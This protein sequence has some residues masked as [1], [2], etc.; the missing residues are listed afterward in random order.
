MLRGDRNLHNVALAAESDLHLGLGLG[1][2]K[3]GGT[4]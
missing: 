4:T 2:M 3:D 1:D